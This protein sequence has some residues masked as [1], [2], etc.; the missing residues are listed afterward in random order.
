MSD[1]VERLRFDAARC[2]ADFSRGIA[3]NIVEAADE[4]ER[5]RDPYRAVDDEDWQFIMSKLGNGG[6]GRFWKAVLTEVRGAL[7]PKENRE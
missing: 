7:E 4:I 3:T 5:L 2:E 6:R 1:I